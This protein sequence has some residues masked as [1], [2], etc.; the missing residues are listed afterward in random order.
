MAFENS[1]L[2]GVTGCVL[3]FGEIW[4]DQEIFALNPGYASNNP[5]PAP[6]SDNSWLDTTG[7]IVDSGHIYAEQAVA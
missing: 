3:D 1:W 7:G 2:E 4:A 5:A 6:F